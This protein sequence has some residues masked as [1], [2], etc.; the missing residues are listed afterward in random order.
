ML[1][2]V[3]MLPHNEGDDNVTDANVDCAADESVDYDTNGDDSDD[4][5]TV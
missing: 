4:N 3:M 1:P 2:M 5:F